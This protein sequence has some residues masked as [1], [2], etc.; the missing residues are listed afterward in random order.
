M[1]QGHWVTVHADREQCR[2]FAVQRHD[3]E[4]RRPP[5]DRSA[6]QLVRNGFTP[7]TPKI[8]EPR[9]E[10]TCRARQTASDGV[11]DAG[12]CDVLADQGA[13]K[14]VVEAEPDFVVDHA[15]DSQLPTGRRHLGHFDRGVDPVE[16]GIR[17]VERADSRDGARHCRCGRSE[18]N[19]RRHRLS[20]MSV[21]VT[22][23]RHGACRRCRK[24]RTNSS[25]IPRPVASG[26]KTPSTGNR[27]PGD[28]L[29]RRNPG[30]VRRVQ[31]RC[32]QHRRRQGE[33]VARL[34]VTHP[35]SPSA[36]DGG[37]IR[38]WRPCV[39]SSFSSIHDMTA[40]RMRRPLRPY[41]GCDGQVITSTSSTS[42]R[43]VSAR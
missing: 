27:S 14:H 35:A 36:P 21:R 42:T 29:R 11:R 4:S 23:G 17:G 10:P 8:L 5:V 12:Q 19:G 24:L 34:D 6:D 32:T 9:A 1:F 18:W 28:R 31:E 20:A 16:I 13:C 39:P 15:V 41:A 3:R 25:P 30:A 26:D 40:S 7:A 22:N 43:L 37:A 38:V 33:V 2:A